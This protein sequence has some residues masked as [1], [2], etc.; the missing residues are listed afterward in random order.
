M[1]QL[2]EKA[3]FQHLVQQEIATKFDQ[4]GKTDGENSLFVHRTTQNT[5]L[6]ACTKHFLVNT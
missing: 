1:T 5:F 6:A 2:C 4:M 3:P